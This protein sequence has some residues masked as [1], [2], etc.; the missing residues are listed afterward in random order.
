MG[1]LR[2]WLDHSDGRSADVEQ[3]IRFAGQ[4]NEFTDGEPRRREDVRLVPAPHMP[5][6]LGELAVDV[7]TS[8]FF[9]GHRPSRA[10]RERGSKPML[11]R[12][13]IRR[14]TGPSRRLCD[15]SRYS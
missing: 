2:L 10:R 9:R 5:H 14:S 8:K 7:L 6:A 1:S 3:V 12:R 4:H 13:G 11:P 15:H